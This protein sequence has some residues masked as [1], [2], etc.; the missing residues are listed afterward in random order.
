ML[1]Q[2]IAYKGRAMPT[3]KGRAMPKNILE[4]QC[5]TTNRKKGECKNKKKTQGG[6][7]TNPNPFPFFKLAKYK[8]KIIKIKNSKN[9]TKSFICQTH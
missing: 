6:A 4:W 9:I 5:P 1:K 2:A 3:S 7:H 8:S